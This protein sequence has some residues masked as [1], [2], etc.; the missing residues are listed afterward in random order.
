MSNSRNLA[1]LL[2]SNGD[3]KSGALDNVPPA[4]VVND[5]TPQLGGDLTSNGNDITFGD[6]DKAIFG[7]GSDL[8]IYH[9]GNNSFIEDSGTG[10]LYIRAAD[11]L[12][13]QS[14][15]D[16]EDF[17]K[18][19]KN[20]AVNLFYNN[21]PKLATTSTGIDV[22]GTVTADGL[23]VDATSANLTLLGST[24]GTINFG[25]AA[26]INIGQ[27]YYDHASNYMR[28]KTADTE[29]MRIDSSGNVG[30]GTSSLSEKLTVR[31][32]AKD[33][34]AA[35][36]IV[37]ANL[38]STAGDPQTVL[39]LRVRDN[40]GATHY[41]HPAQLIFGNDHYIDGDFDV[42]KIE[43]GGS[44]AGHLAFST[45]G[46]GTLSEAMRID[47]SGNLKFNSGYGSVATAYGVRAWINWNGNGSIIN[48]SG[49]VSSYSRAGVGDYD[50]NWATAMP[51]ANYSVTCCSGEER[52]DRGLS[53]NGLTTTKVTM[54]YETTGGGRVDGNPLMIMAVR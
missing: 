7:A 34:T 27:I 48:G 5:T 15:S 49:G 10:V 30:I 43:A 52:V 33:V 19:F 9:N 3:V 36:F 2:D 12:R 54:V 13:L 35:K 26:D 39:E 18:A 53:S 20:G 1:D 41:G 38:D 44:T 24:D 46:S 8:Q 47:S 23:T 31:Q 14:Y 25:D 17:L 32:T 42:A 29:R 4:D 50:I 11:E 28:F 16:N 45:L 21:A 51:D 40:S 37:D 22:T 6:N